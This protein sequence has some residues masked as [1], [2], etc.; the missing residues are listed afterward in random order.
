M[1]GFR[2]WS[3]TDYS[4]S[5]DYKDCLKVSYL[6]YG[7]E[8]CPSTG[9]KHHQGYFELKTQMTMS[10]I[11]KALKNTEIHLEVSK[12]SAKKNKT[13]CSKESVV[14]EFGTPK[15]QGKRN[16]ITEVIDEL[17]EGATMRQIT[18]NP[19]SY[20]SIKIAETWLKYHE[21]KRTWK[22]EVYWYYGPPG[23][24]KSMRALEEAGPDCYTLG[25]NGK[26]FEGYDGHEHIVIDDFRE[27][28]MPFNS[29]LRLLDRYEY[30]FEHKGG[31]RQCLATAI[32]I[33]SP[34][35]PKYVYENSKEDMNQLLRRIDEII[36]FEKNHSEVITQKSGVVLAPDSS[37]FI[38]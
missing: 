25:S 30:R 34:S 22:P 16:D 28:M 13:Y 7:L 24:G 27:N 15:Q 29:L 26:W 1:S 8:T 20:Q 19:K 2:N 23:T 33:T 35:H 21:K 36:Y 31:S 38:N 37:S 12:G 9:R 14:E 10:A 17:K 6:I 18:S 4:L 11:K 5:K 32:W 3:F